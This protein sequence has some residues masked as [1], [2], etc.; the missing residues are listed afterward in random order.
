MTYEP[1][2]CDGVADQLASYLEGELLEPTR[3]ALEAHA[4]SCAEPGRAPAT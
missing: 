1:M 2:T 4:A 3:L